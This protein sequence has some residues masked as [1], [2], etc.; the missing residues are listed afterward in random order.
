M[1]YVLSCVQLFATPWTVALQTPLSLGFFRQESWKGLLLR[2][3]RDLP[4]PGIEPSSPALAGGFFTTEPPARPSI[5]TVM[6]IHLDCT[7]FQS[8]S[9]SSNAPEAL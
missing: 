3:L 5:I 6:N 4:N 9:H 8:A 2:P 7:C 1:E